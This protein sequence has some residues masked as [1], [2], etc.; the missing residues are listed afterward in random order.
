MLK[1][2]LMLASRKIYAH[3]YT[4]FDVYIITTSEKKNCFTNLM[5]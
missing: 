1:I 5:P 4:L 3:A 2:L